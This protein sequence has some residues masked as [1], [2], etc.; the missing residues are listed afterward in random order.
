MFKQ[1]GRILSGFHAAAVAIT[2][3]AVGALPTSAAQPKGPQEAHATGGSAGQNLPSWNEG[4]SKQAIM[5][6]V[7][8]VTRQGGLDYVP[9]AERV[10]TFDNDGTLWPEQPMPIQ[11]AFALDRVKALSPRHPEW[12]TTEPFASM[13]QG[14]IK[15]AVAGGEPAFAQILRAIHAGM[16]AEEFEKVVQDWLATAKHP[17]TGRPYTE[18]A[19]QPMLELLA[20]LEANGFKIFVICSGDIDFMR[21]FTER[22]YGAPLEHVIGSSREVKLRRNDAKPVVV[23]LSD[24]T[25]N[26]KKYG[27]LVD[28]Q[29]PLGLLP[30]AAFGNSDDDIQMLQWATE[31]SSA[32]LGLIVH[33]T[34]AE[35]E[36]AYDAYAATGKL[37]NG[38]DQAQANDW[39][40]V[41]MKHDWKI[42]FS[43]EQR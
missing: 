11:F 5:E 12:T 9:P 39:A 35:R 25:F 32:G 16:T 42:V 10:A 7:G 4:A 15:G 17:E 13:L 28:S 36:W 18:M 27:T 21:I 20:Y 14:D 43:F 26:G 23:A 2:L 31:G 40:I 33:H 41:D 8:K 30:I 37:D 29:T 3:V 6:F 22:V 24:N 19:Y 38:L 1:S 34:D